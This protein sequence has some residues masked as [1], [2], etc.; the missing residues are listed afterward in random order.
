MEIMDAFAFG[1]LSM[2]AACLSVEFVIRMAGFYSN[3]ARD[4]GPRRAGG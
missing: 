1:F 2:T 4:N 3:L